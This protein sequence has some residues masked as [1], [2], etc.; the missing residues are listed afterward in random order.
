MDTVLVKLVDRKHPEVEHHALHVSPS[1]CSG[2]FKRYLGSVLGGD[3]GYRLYIHGRQFEGCLGE[4]I[5]S[6]GL[7]VERGVVI[8]YEPDEH[9]APDVTTEVE[10]SVS[11]LSVARGSPSEIWCGTYG[12]RLRAYTYGNGTILPKRTTEYMGIRGMAYGDSIYIY[13]SSGE[14][15]SLESGDV[16]FKVDGEITSLAS[17]CGVVSAG[18]HEGECYVFGDRLLMIHKFKA[19]VSSTSIRGDDLEFVCVDGRIGV[20]SISTSTFRTRDVKHN[21]TSADTR[22]NVR[23]LGTSCSGL[24]VECKEES[25][26]VETSIRF[27]SRV[28]MYNDH[29]VAQA[30]QH[31]VSIINTRDSRELRRITVDGYISD[32]AWVGNLL[33][34]G[35]GP[36]IHGYTIHSLE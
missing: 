32:I 23:I 1:F 17:S 26:F 34:V 8:E 13:N 30:S 19:P 6:R 31:V 2:D 5:S 20:F 10:D 12:G 9:C 29:V 25:V 22:G 3:G 11:F 24:V 16:L 27:S 7:E 33:L 36:R 28:V 14:V 15:L 35:V 21:V 4:E 18:T